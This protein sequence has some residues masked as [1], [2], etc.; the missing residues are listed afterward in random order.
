MNIDKTNTAWFF[1]DSFTYGDGCREGFEYYT[2][3]PNGKLWTTIVSEKL[4]LSEKNLG[5]PGNS[6]PMILNELITNLS[7][8]K[9][10]DCVF[11]TDTFPTRF[12]ESTT[13]K[14]R[15][16]SS[17]FEN[18]FDVNNL[19]RQKL[20]TL[21]F[22][23]D[24]VE[25][26]IDVWHSFYLTQYDSIRKELNLRNVNVMFWS[27]M[28]WAGTSKFENISTATN[29]K[30]EDGHFS[31]KGHEQMAEWILNRDFNKSIKIN[32]GLI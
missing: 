23:V 17:V 24:C 12:L 9:S 30:I 8:F 29:H 5:R 32:K 27:Y 18:N 20:S 25:P 16:R 22:I 1:G 6:I 3:Y 14:S 21:N 7:N 15:I 10:G 13:D 11:L 2:Q 19:T 31:W 4:G 28:N 26:F